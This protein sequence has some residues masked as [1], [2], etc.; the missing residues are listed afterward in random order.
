MPNYTTR[1]GLDFAFGLANGSGGYGDFLFEEDL[2]KQF[3]TEYI[4]DVSGNP[5]PVE[6]PYYNH[7]CTYSNPAFNSSSNEGR[8]TARIQK[9][10]PK[11]NSITE[12]SYESSV[13]GSNFSLS[14]VNFRRQ[15]FSLDIVPMD[16][17]NV[18]IVCNFCDLD[19]NDEKNP[20]ESE[21]P[22]IEDYYGFRYTRVFESS[23][24]SFIRN[25]ANLYSTTPMKERIRFG[26]TN[27][28]NRIARNPF[29]TKECPK[30]KPQSEDSLIFVS[31]INTQ[32]ELEDPNSTKVDP[33]YFGPYDDLDSFFSLKSIDGQKYADK[34]NYIVINLG[35]FKFENGIVYDLEG[36]FH[37]NLDNFRIYRK[38]ELP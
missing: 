20:S 25:L 4:N 18:T 8:L 1:Y 14:Y 9:V 37:L 16:T 27:D 3:R 12:S 22:D 38:R 2:G 7:Y 24:T 31:E 30:L 11:Y 10:D 6:V 33:I 29:F 35:N 34:N 17:E 15:Q 28:V 32:D 13:D 19:W 5:Q 26:E 21:Y 23:P 36:P